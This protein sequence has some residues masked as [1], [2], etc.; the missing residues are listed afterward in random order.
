M[1]A[2]RGRSRRAGALPRDHRPCRD[3]VRQDRHPG[4]QRRL[5]DES[6][7]ARGDQRR[8]VGP[9]VR[10]ERRRLFHLVKAA[11]PHMGP[12]SSII[13]T[14]SVNSDMPS[15]DAG[16]LRRDQGGDRELL[17]QPGSAA[18]GEGHPGQQRRTGTD[19]DA[20]DSGHDAAGEGRQL[21]RR[22][23]AGP[24]RSAGRARAGVRAAGLATRAATS[25]APGA[26]TGGRPI[27]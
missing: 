27:L 18:R 22:H 9:H 3:R 14:S 19:L 25:P 20:A 21:R 24:G 8:G 15:P 26:V 13:G 10:L 16:A 17:R 1:R 4:Q 6:R 23:T 7:L 11:V 2:G 5:P 12:G